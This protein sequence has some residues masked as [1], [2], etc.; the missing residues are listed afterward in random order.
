MNMRLV[1]TRN[2]RPVL[3]VELS[4]ILSNYLWVS[5]KK[6]SGMSA[7]ALGKGPTP[8]VLD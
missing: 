2:C 8:N 4:Q 1:F 7:C 5:Y 6:S 3:A